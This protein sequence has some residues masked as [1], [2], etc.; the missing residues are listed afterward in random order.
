MNIEFLHDRAAVAL[1]D[2]RPQEWSNALW[3]TISP[4]PKALHECWKV[5]TSKDGFRQ[6][7]VSVKIPYGKLPQQQ[8]YDYCIKVIRTCYNYSDDTKIFGTWELNK[9]GD[10]HFHFIMTDPSIR[11]QTTLKMFQ[12]DIL[13]C[14]TVIKNL[15]KGMIDY[16]NNIVF[17]NDSIEKR[18]EY[19][20]KDISENLGLMPYYYCSNKSLLSKSRTRTSGDSQGEVPLCALSV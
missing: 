19:M 17:V 20:T 9:Q 16:M 8:Q 4:N 15:S 7:K 12:R 18:F 5:V 2:R 11:G 6:K 3:V 10:V 13:N 1:V 14:E